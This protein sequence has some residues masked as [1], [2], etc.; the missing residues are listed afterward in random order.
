MGIYKIRRLITDKLCYSEEV[1]WYEILE[2]TNPSNYG[3]EDLDVWVDV[4]DVWV[5]VPDRRFDFK[6]VKISFSARLAGTSDKNGY[7]EDCK[8]T[9]SGNGVFNFTEGSKDVEIEWFD[10]KEELEIY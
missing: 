3:T 1:K 9:V 6:N 7:Y 5:D 2:E 8:F 10:I 4:N